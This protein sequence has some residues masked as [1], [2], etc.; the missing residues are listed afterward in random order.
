LVAELLPAAIV[1]PK[2]KGGRKGAAQ[3]AVETVLPEAKLPLAK[4]PE[5]AVVVPEKKIRNRKTAAPKLT[6]ARPVAAEVSSPEPK[7]QRK[8]SVRS[9]KDQPAE[10]PSGE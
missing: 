1:E 6:E 8:R 10:E 5:A 3:K 4:L 9:K 2:K 7:P